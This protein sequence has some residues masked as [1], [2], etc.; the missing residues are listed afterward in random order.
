MPG[1]E[2]R[3]AVS[4]TVEPTWAST[5]RDSP[6]A[7]MKVIF[8]IEQSDSL[9]CRVTPRKRV[10]SVGDRRYRERAYIEQARRRRKGIWSGRRDSR[11]RPENRVCHMVGG[12]T[13]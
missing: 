8:A 2:L 13:D 6:V 3:S 4:M 5:V 10:N 11:I 1:I 12:L 7:S 9:E